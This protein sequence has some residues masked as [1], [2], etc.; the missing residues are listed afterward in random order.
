MVNWNSSIVD[1]LLQSTDGDGY[2]IIK[3]AYYIE[4]FLKFQSNNEIFLVILHKKYLKND[5]IK[6]FVA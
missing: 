2:S 6:H 3:S 5:A 4:M 1:Y